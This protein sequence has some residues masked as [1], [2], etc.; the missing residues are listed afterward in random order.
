ME[1]QH[2]Y[3]YKKSNKANVSIV[4]LIFT[5][6]SIIG[7]SPFFSGYLA[8]PLFLTYHIPFLLLLA[9]FMLTQKISSALISLSIIMI[10]LISALTLLTESLINFNRYIF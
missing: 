7:W 8:V 6:I 10:I 5:Y 2:V 4:A 1:N 9:Y 3:F